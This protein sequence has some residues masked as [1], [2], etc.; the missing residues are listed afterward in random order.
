[1]TRSPDTS[2]LKQL[3][4]GSVK[5]NFVDK[6][7][8]QALYALTGVVLANLLT[9]TDFGLVGAVLV[10][11]AFASLLVDSGF[12]YALLQRKRPSRLDYS[13]VLWFNLAVAV[14]IYIVLFFCAPLISDLFQHDR[15]LIAL[16]RVMF[17]SFIF[18]AACIVQVNRLMKQMRVKTV[19][20]ANSVGLFAG[21]VV[22]I[23]LAVAG[24]GAWAIVWQ[25]IAL[26]LVKCVVLWCVGRWLPLFRFSWASLKSFF[27]VGSSMMATSFLNTL[28]QNIYSFFIGFR[29]G[30]APL[31]YYTQADKCINMGI[32]TVQ[33]T[34]TSA[35][36]P[37]LSEIQDDPG[38]FARASSKMNRLTAYMLFPVMGFLAVMATQIFHCLFGTKW[39]MSVVL[40]QILLVR[41]V[42]TVLNAVYANYAIALA[43]TRLVFYLEVVRD[44]VA[45]LLLAV[46]Y[47]WIA[48]AAPGN[49]VWGRE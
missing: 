22:G 18:N 36:L 2:Q 40:F 44:A 28:F 39:D 10:F 4:A 11:Q 32:T 5:W 14:A 38:R 30:L 46:T 33:Q 27:A 43:R 13:T 12:S 26:N 19:A 21:A 42:F 35:F 24:Y 17:L 23:A 9:D 48:A 31:G 1:M 49:A 34:L 8:Q 6:V 37:T 45:L 29:A 41:G 3:T 47:P 16:S 15:R 20:L 25:T 7:A